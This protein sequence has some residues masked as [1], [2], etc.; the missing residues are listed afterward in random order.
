MFTFTDIDDFI[1]W[2]EPFYNNFNRNEIVDL[3]KYKRLKHSLI[4]NIN[5][6]WRYSVSCKK[7]ISKLIVEIN[8]II[9]LYNFCINDCNYT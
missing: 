6:Q 1:L 5:Y 4:L 3:I 2:N 7:E 9:T 8:K